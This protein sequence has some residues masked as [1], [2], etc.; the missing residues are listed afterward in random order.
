M[1]IN[2]YYQKIKKM[3]A[4]SKSKVGNYINIIIYDYD[5][6]LFYAD[7]RL[8]NHDKRFEL[9]MKDYLSNNNSLQLKDYS[10]H[11]ETRN[12]PFNRYI[13]A[14]NSVLDAEYSQYGIIQV[15][16]KIQNVD[17]KVL[18]SMLKYIHKGYIIKANA[19]GGWCFVS[20]DE[21]RD[22]YYILCY[23]N[24]KYNL[25]YASVVLSE[26]NYYMITGG[27]KERDFEVA[28]NVLVI[29]NSTDIDNSVLSYLED[30]N[31]TEY[32]ILNQFE[33]YQN[34]YSE[35]DWGKIFV[36]G[37]KNGLHTIVFNT[38]GY[39]INQLD[40]LTKLVK[41]ID[42]P[43]ELKIVTNYDLSYL[44]DVKNLKIIAL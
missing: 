15:L 37:I 40:L 14:I 7:M 2:L 1:C 27:I 30:N 8:K 41:S 17:S 39:S 20:E 26:I 16:E 24:A 12:A 22:N 38:Q 42:L 43:H 18:T 34:L 21:L 10:A 3:I 29:E 31:I 33:T 9:F 4:L 5:G 35:S 32:Q 19:A 13:S 23:D 25:K 44:N 28:A 11:L 36:N 6:L